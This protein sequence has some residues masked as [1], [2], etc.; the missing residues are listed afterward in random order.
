M[1][2]VII[3]TRN[4]ADYLAQSL[5]SLTRQTLPAT[6]FEVLVVDN[7]STDHTPQVV[8]DFA[9]RFSSLKRLYEP[10]PGLHTG[11]HAGMKAASS[12]IIVY[13][14]DDIEVF[15]TWLAAISEPFVDPQTVMAGGNILPMYLAEPPAWI[16]KMWE[17]RDAEGRRSIPALSVME[18]PVA[19]GFVS[20]HS[21][22]GGNLAIRKAV[23]MEAGG[24]HP[25]GMPKDKIQFRGDGEI[26]V[27]RY[28]AASGYKCA[29][30]AD[31]SVYH[32][33][34]PERMTFTYFRQRGFNEGVTRSYA[35]L[36]SGNRYMGAGT[37][38]LPKRIVA[39]GLQ[40][41]RNLTADEDVKE[42]Q[43]QLKLGYREGYAFHQKAYL[44]DPAVREWV[45]KPYYW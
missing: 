44:E 41:F 27:S 13:G 2:S 30:H 45:H 20:P 19:K 21:V 37:S 23:L 24:F 32:K 43:R 33:V 22:W 17:R 15:P 4:R 11:R 34:I 40:E 26:H 1:L 5:A 10:E 14:E 16:R 8:S 25:D 28:V 6:E 42:A 35:V 12:D 31:A 39:R 38:S 36:R 7:G 18:L 29:F 9:S 3:P